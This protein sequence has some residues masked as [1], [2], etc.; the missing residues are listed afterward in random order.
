MDYDL[1]VMAET[2]IDNRMKNLLRIC[3]EVVRMQ[4]RTGFRLQRTG[5]LI[6]KMEKEV[7]AIEECEMI[8]NRAKNLTED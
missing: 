1:V 8:I 4:G 2:D 3:R 7:E 6:D 5:E